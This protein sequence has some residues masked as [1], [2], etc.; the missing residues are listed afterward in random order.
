ML[1]DYVLIYYI[2]W[3]KEWNRTRIYLVAGIKV[4]FENEEYL[5]VVQSKWDLIELKYVICKNSEKLLLECLEL[6][7]WDL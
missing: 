4:Y 5:H 2:L 1:K 7:L 6:M 3:K